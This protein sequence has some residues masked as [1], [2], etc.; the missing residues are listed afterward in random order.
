[1]DYVPPFPRPFHDM[2]DWETRRL[3]R[4][5]FHEVWD[6]RRE[7]TIDE[8]W[9]PECYGEQEGIEGRVSKDDF[10]RHW[11]SVASAIPDVNTRVEEIIV[12]GDKAMV[13]WRV[14]GTH[15]G[16]GWPAPPSGRAVDF[17]GVTLLQFRNGQ[18][19]YGFDRWNRGEVIASLMRVRIDELVE[20]FGLTPREAQVALLLAERFTHKRIASDLGIKPNTARVHAQRVLRKLGVHSK[21]AVAEALAGASGS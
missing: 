1:M 10:K 9:A 21:H 15:T 16:T 13:S 7:A 20:T 2:D 14:T 4:R 8:L 5:W 17:R 19:V 11:H 6:L 3:A 12:D 18:L